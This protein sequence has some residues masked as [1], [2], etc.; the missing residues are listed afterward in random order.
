MTEIPQRARELCEV[1]RAPE[2][3]STGTLY[4]VNQKCLSVGVDKCFRRRTIVARV[5]LLRLTFMKHFSSTVA[6]RS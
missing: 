2:L 1:T 4:G 6:V 3:L 5:G